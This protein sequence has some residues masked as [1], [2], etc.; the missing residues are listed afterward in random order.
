[1]IAETCPDASGTEAW[2]EPGCITTS[3]EC[4]MVSCANAGWYGHRRN[5]IVQISIGE[6]Q[7]AL[8]GKGILNRNGIIF[9]MHLQGMPTNLKNIRRLE[10]CFA[11]KNS[12]IALFL[13]GRHFFIKDAAIFR[14]I[15][16]VMS[17]ARK[18]KYEISFIIISD[19]AVT[20]NLS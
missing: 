13:G 4:Q 12:V 2:G 11:L 9:I 10:N 5:T 15:F 1:M 19:I 8:T 3:Y 20:N 7:K 14:D 18:T 6:R 17:S 16:L